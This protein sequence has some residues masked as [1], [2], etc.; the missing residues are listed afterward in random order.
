V[1]DDHNEYA[2]SVIANSLLYFD[3]KTKEMGQNK[4][5]LERKK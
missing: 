3:F 5:L 4:C 2:M 1:F